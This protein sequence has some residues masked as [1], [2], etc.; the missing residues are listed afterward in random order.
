MENILSL[1]RKVHELAVRLHVAAL[2]VQVRVI[3]ATAD[4]EREAAAIASA[5]A[6]KARQLANDAVVAADAADQHASIVAEA[7]K[8]EAASIG[9]N[10][11]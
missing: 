6:D 10:L 2:G 9:G 4:A 1:T 11:N 5:A 8:T 3:R 7:A